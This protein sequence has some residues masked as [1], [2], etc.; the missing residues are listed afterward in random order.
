M[1]T[2]AAKPVTTAWSALDPYFSRFDFSGG[3]TVVLAVSGGGDSVALAHGF[4]AFCA[5]HGL[6]NRVIWATVDHGL[7]PES[8]DEALGVGAQAAALGVVHIIANWQR[9]EGVSANQENARKARY[10]LLASIAREHGASTVL[11]GHTADDQ[12]ETLLMRSQRNGQ[13]AGMAGIAPATLFQR[14][15][16]FLRPLLGVR[17]STLR[18]ILRQAGVRWIDDPSNDNVDFERVRARKQLG[19]MDAGEIKSVIGKAAEQGALRKKMARAGAKVIGD[20]ERVIFGHDGSVRIRFG[21]ERGAEHAALSALLAYAGRQPLM[22]AGPIAA[23]AWTFVSGIADQPNGTAIT[24]HGCL[25]RKSDDWIE[26]V[27]EQRNDGAGVFG[28][29]HLLVSFDFALA[30][31]INSRNGGAALASPPFR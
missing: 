12:A 3:K 16:W 22:P 10:D 25:L 6:D 1:L 4:H 13:G 14:D 23:K 9:G 24:L 28:F 20:P 26:I 29:D 2:G 30:Q 15:V 21:N 31:A 17:R 27:R 8:A 5:R 19:V 18:D 11:T 7:R